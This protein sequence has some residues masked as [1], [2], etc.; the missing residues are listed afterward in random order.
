MMMRY[1][2]RNVCAEENKRGELREH[3]KFLLASKLHI[4]LNLTITLELHHS[5]LCPTSHFPS[6]ST[7]FLFP[8]HAL[9]PKPS[10]SLNK[11]TDLNYKRLYCY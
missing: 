6:P 8:L 7:L 11:Q 3:G 10:P 9:T 1:I 5:S 2:I 4:H